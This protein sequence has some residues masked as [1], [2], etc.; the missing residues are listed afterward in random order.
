[1]HGSG[2]KPEISSS[3]FPPWC[4]RAVAS[5]TL[6]VLHQRGGGHGG[7]RLVINHILPF[8]KD[9]V[10]LLI[11][12]FVNWVETSLGSYAVSH[13]QSQF[14][15]WSWSWFVTG[16]R[17]PQLSQKL[18][19]QSCRTSHWL[20]FCWFYSH[21]CVLYFSWF[22][23]VMCI[24]WASFGVSRLVVLFLDKCVK[25]DLLCVFVFVLRHLLPSPNLGWSWSWILTVDSS[26]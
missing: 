5:A 26:S 19:Y 3:H 25:S 7:G 11:F 10:G 6:A 14:F 18:K 8:L 22:S 21:C 4:S 24:E 16:E 12:Q 13:C 9:L 2:C 20:R 15:C 23:N 17:A 1:M